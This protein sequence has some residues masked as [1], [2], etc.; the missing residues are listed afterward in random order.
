VLSDDIINGHQ[1]QEDPSFQFH[2][3]L[4][5]SIFNSDKFLEFERHFWDVQH[6]VHEGIPANAASSIMSL[7]RNVAEQEEI[8]NS[9]KELKYWVASILDQMQKESESRSMLIEITRKLDDAL[10]CRDEE[11]RSGM[12]HYVK[13]MLGSVGVSC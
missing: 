8:M 4:D 13:H 1:A 11:I 10:Q 6:S 12:H 9:L 7:Q 5:H 3:L 2:F